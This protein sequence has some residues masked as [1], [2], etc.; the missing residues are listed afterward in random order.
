M[1]NIIWSDYLQYR[2]KLRGFTIAKI[3]EIIK[4]SGERYYDME[5]DRLIA[6]GKHDNQLVIIPYESQD[7]T[8]TPITI[9]STTRQQ[10]RFRLTSGRYI[11][12]E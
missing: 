2:A 3:E 12:N 7:N 1:S 4:Y 9:H 11:I 5:T 10:I 6:V 8:V